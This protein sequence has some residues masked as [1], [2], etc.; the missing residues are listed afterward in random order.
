[1]MRSSALA[2]NWRPHALHWWLCLPLCIWP[3]FLNCIDPHPGHV[4]L[5]TMAAVGLPHRGDVLTNRSTDLD[6]EHHYLC[7]TTIG[8][9]LLL[10]HD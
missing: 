6:C 4:S 8:C 9:A 7:S 2:T 10:G 1:M 5:T 3:F